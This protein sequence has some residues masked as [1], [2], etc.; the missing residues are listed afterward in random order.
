MSQIRQQGASQFWPGSA[1]F[2][3]PRG[4]SALRGGR[5]LQGLGRGG[6]WAAHPGAL[7]SLGL[8]VVLGLLGVSGSLQ[9]ICRSAFFCAAQLTLQPARTIAAISG[10]YYAQSYTFLSD[11]SGRTTAEFVSV[12]HH[13]KQP[14][15]LAWRAMP[16]SC[17]STHCHCP[18]H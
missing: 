14:E 3:L 17:C 11:Q 4:C 6:Q 10:R 2:N 9:D 5:S 12:G 18:G 13:Y 1:T 16:E 7:S 8:S 15:Q